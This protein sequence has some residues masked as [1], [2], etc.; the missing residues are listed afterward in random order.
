[1]QAEDSVLVDRSVEELAIEPRHL[2]RRQRLVLS[3]GAVA[4]LALALLTG[5]HLVPGCGQQ[6]DQPSAPA[7]DRPWIPASDPLVRDLHY[8]LLDRAVTAEDDPAFGGLPEDVRGSARR[9]GD[10]AGVTLY[11][12]AGPGFACLGAD[13][14]RAYD[15]T[16]NDH[17]SVCL[18]NTT[19]VNQGLTL[20]FTPN[21]SEDSLLVV[22]VPDSMELITTPSTTRLA[23]YLS[24]VVLRPGPEPVYLHAPGQTPVDV[25]VEADESFPTW[26][27]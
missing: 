4:L 6:P 15:N 20:P 5:D 11:L 19:I 18:L 24:A 21:G 25:H 2:G 8:K 17:S 27:C 16:A 9:I 12:G 1:M 7:S 22:A 26:S 14:V 13:H 23:T 10:V 3:S